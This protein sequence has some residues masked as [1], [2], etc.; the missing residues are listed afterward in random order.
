[1]TCPKR[2]AKLV[3]SFEKF[4]WLQFCSKKLLVFSLM[5]YTLKTASPIHLKNGS[6]N[7]DVVYFFQNFINRHGKI[8]ISFSFS[9]YRWLLVLT[10]RVCSTQGFQWYYFFLVPFMSKSCYRIRISQQNFITVFCFSL[11]WEKQNIVKTLV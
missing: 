3:H 11:L 5:H 2:G 1:M 9:R 7:F 6:S 4:R 8:V 10:S